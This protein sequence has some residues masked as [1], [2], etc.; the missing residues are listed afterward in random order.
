MQLCPQEDKSWR[1]KLKGGGSPVASGSHQAT[2]LTKSD[3]HRKEMGWQ[4][5]QKLVPLHMYLCLTS[6]THFPCE[7]RHNAGSLLISVNF[8]GT[9]V[10]E[11]DLSENVARGI[12]KDLLDHY[13]NQRPRHMGQWLT[14]TYH[15]CF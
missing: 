1:S 11:G 4:S 7:A 10:G 13:G 6:S 15:F 5:V 2:H 9:C 12:C 8:I 3:H 14:A